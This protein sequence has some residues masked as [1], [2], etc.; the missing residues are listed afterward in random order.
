MSSIFNG[1]AGILSDVLGAEVQY[2]RAA[3]PGRAVQ[4]M[5]R[6]SGAEAF[7]QDGHPVL[8]VAPTWRVG[9]DLVPQI[10]RGDR[11]EPGNGRTYKIL[12]YD[13]SA[14]PADDAFL[15]CELER[16]FE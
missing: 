12:N 11:I 10:A 9:R 6:E 14:S 8:V 3:E 2:F 4:S 13:L 1:M 7:D 15:I 5:F 16:V